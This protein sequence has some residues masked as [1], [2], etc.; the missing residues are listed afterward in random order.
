MIHSLHERNILIH[1]LL[2]VRDMTRKRGGEFF[3]LFLTIAYIEPHKFHC[4]HVY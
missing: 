2:V 3:L 1:D 4:V